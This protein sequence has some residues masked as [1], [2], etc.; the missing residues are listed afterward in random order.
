MHLGSIHILQA[1]LP[2]NDSPETNER[3]ICSTVVSI[4]SIGPTNVILPAKKQTARFWMGTR[5]VNESSK[6][7]DDFLF[8]LS[9]DGKE[10]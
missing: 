1:V 8:T 2:H 3:R 4:M 5:A 7:S 10:N 9:S 6:Q